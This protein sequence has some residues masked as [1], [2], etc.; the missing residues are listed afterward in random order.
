[1]ATVDELAV[2]VLR[3]GG[4][5]RI[6]A[7]GASML[8]FLRNGDIVAVTP[9]ALTG[10]NI[11]DIVCYEAAAGRLFLHRAIRRDGPRIVTKGDAL[12]CT[13]VI[14]PAQLLG[15]VVAIERRGCTKRL[16]SRVARWRNR[17]IASLS[18]LIPPLVSVA[19]PV[20]RVLRACAAW[21]T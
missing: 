10:V 15:T 18:H 19:R 3:R 14:D 20:R 12:S 1:M 9:T 16:D 6:K 7:R 8:P 5:V 13:E 17:A 4:P 2:E 11:G 21:M